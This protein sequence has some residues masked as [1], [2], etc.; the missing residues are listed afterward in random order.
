M[1]GESDVTVALHSI[2]RVIFIPGIDDL[3]VLPLVRQESLPP[4]KLGAAPAFGEQGTP[5][6]SHTSYEQWSTV[7]QNRQ[8]ESSEGNNEDTASE[9]ILIQ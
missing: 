8:R 4:E 9:S 7:L 6:H 1:L 5:F 3:T 2:A